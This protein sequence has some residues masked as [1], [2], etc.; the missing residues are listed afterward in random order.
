[1]LLHLH[2]SACRPY[3]IFICHVRWLPSHL[4]DVGLFQ[5]TNLPFLPGIVHDDMIAPHLNLYHLTNEAPVIR[6]QA[7]T[8]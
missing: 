7:T 8:R 2:E 3:L 5:D 4:P 6:V 1:M